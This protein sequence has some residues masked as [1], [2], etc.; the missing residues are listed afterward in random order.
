MS[1]KTK[2]HEDTVFFVDKQEFKVEDRTYTVGEVLEMA[3]EDPAQTTLVRRDGDDLTKLTDVDE[4]LDIKPGTH[5]V[6]FHN[7]PTP[8]S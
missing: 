2:G 7:G 4:Q 1:T 5:F 3:G 8:V 6:V